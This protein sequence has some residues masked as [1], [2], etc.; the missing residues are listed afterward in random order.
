M[1]WLSFIQHNL[2]ILLSFVRDLVFL[3]YLAILLKELLLQEAK[4]IHYR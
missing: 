2:L 1:A 3:F 4:F